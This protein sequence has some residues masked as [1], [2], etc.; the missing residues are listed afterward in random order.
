VYPL[1]KKI[2]NQISISLLLPFS[3]FNI[4]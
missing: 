1:P 3:L 2:K 4:I